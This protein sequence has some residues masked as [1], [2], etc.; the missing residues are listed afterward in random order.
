MAADRHKNRAA[1]SRASLRSKRKNVIRR[2][3]QRR[4][5]VLL[6]LHFKSKKE[7]KF[8]HF[9]LTLSN[10]LTAHSRSVR[11]GRFVLRDRG[12]EI[13]K[14]GEKRRDQSRTK[15]LLFDTVEEDL[16]KAMSKLT[17]KVDGLFLLRLLPIVQSRHVISKLLRTCEIPPNDSIPLRM[18]K[19]DNHKC[20]R[21][22]CETCTF[23]RLPFTTW[24]KTTQRRN[25]AYRS[26]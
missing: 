5:S 17:L 19:L 20:G 24:G 8:I 16:W 21:Q 14:R 23:R 3:H 7:A 1:R 10:R 22:P 18:C 26:G 25:F 15:N 6:F 13:T 2:N 11:L 12:D 9:P 4:I